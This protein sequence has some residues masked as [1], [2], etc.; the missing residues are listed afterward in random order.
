M[1]NAKEK[2]FDR[3]DQTFKIFKNNFI[4]L[5]LPMF[6][7]KFIAVVVLWTFLVVFFFSNLWDI[8][9]WTFDLFNLVFNS[10][11]IMSIIVWLV[12]LLL[13]LILYIPIYIWLIRS[14]KQAVEWED[15]T[16]MDNL[17]FGFNRIFASFKT[18]WYIFSYVALIPALLFISWWL[19]FNAWY[20]YE[21][22][23]Y[24]KEIWW[25]VMI[26]SVILFIIF[27]IY[28]WIKATFPIYSAVNH[29]NFSKVDFLNSVNITDNQWWRILWNTALAWMIIWFAVS[30]VS[31]IL[32]VFSYSW[33][34]FASIKSL[35]D[36]LAI[37][38]NITIYS[39]ILSGFLN[40]IFSTIGTVFIIIF[41]YL[42]FL[43]LK[44]ESNPS[45]NLEL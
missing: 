33:I 39:Q 5:F 8:A 16:T 37:T 19:L 18:Y 4:Q 30:M 38:S 15:I 1:I 24:L 35:D 32:K 9:N 28:R 17:I 3:F 21:S 26:F 41:V 23:A 20:Y 27:A 14:I 44:F 22:Y 2:F 25:V 42:L 12:L 40:N 31:N 11:V 45:R 29:D 43:R 10:F 6:L 34:D 13:Y 36:V 7:Y